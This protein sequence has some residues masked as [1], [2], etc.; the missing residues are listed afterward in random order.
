MERRYSIDVNKLFAA[1]DGKRRQNHHTW[2]LVSYRLG[3]SRNTL[4]QLAR[5]SRGLKP[6]GIDG[7]VLAGVLVY[8]DRPIKDFIVENKK[9]VENDAYS[10][11]N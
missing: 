10:Q 3:V 6:K 2:L 4:T 9:E 1:L 5:S 8:L 11:Q 7:N